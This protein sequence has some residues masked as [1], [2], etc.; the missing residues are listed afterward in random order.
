MRTM[1]F[2]WMAVFLVSGG[3]L[4]AH[5]GYSEYDRNALVTLDGSVKRVVWENPHIVMTLEMQNQGEYSVEWVS[6]NQ[7][8]RQGVA[9]RPV[10]EG[11][12]LRV[13]G[14]VNKNPAKRILTLVREVR[15]PADGWCWKDARYAES[16]NCGE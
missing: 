5:H 16:L 10:K 1:V 4:R 13:V 12:R 15:R 14:S 11:D 9:S 7:L 3:L 2:G 8:A 6:P